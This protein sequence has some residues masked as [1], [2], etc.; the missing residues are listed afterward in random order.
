MRIRTRKLIGT[1][2]ILILIP[3]YALLAMMLAILILPG[4]SRLVELLFYLVV[5]V[6]WALPGAVLISWMGRPD[7]DPG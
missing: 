4:Q 6:G 7:K 3:V 1:A 5:G 2:L